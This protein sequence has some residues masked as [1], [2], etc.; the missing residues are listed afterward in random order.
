MRVKHFLKIS[1]LTVNEL[2]KVLRLS[3]KIKKELKTKGRNRP[4]FKQKTLVSIYEKPSLR[5]RIS[6]DIR[7]TQLG[8]HSIYLG[9]SDIVM[10][11]RE[12]ASD[13][14]KVAGSMADLIFARTFK[15]SSVVEL[16]E[17]STVPVING[18]SD[19]EH[20]CQILADFL[21]IKEKL[22][23]ISSLKIVFLG[24]GNNNVTHSFSVMSAMM[25]NEFVVAA[26]KGYLMDKQIFAESKKWAKKTGGKIEQTNNPK[27]AVKNADVVITDTWISMGEEKEAKKR[28]KVFPR[29]QVTEKIMSLA[30]KRAIFMHCLPAYRGKEVAGKVIDGPRSVVFD[31]A[32]NRLHAQK[33]LMVYLLNKNY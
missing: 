27:T 19:L 23:K 14:G 33:G 6:F 32:E 7:M 24:D 12:S 3:L 1:D 25:G 9:P 8:G 5:T 30:K 22:G 21:T 29:F 13:V 26:P 16:S 11:K 15:H 28:L 4:V 18:L 17:G 10:G 2:R 20:P 31:E